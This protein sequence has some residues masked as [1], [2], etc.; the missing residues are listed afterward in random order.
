ML[1]YWPAARALQPDRVAVINTPAGDAQWQVEVYTQRAHLVVRSPGVA[2]KPSDRDYE[3]W[4]LPAGG[5]P[6]VSLGV[7]PVRG[8]TTHAL[9]EAQRQALARA[10]QIAVS[11]K[12]LGGSPT[13]H[14][15]GP[16]V[17]VAPLRA[18]G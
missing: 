2:V 3:L 7:I 13:G 18:V 16:V 11:V 6:A 9:S 14:A 17:F 5:A 1:A 12:P 15:T 8:E 10:L 4:A